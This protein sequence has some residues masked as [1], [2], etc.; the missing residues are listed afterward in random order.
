MKKLTAIAALLLI[1]GLTRAEEPKK[2]CPM[3]SQKPGCCM[4]AAN[5]SLSGPEQKMKGCPMDQEG[6]GDQACC[7]IPDKGLAE[8][9]ATAMKNAKETELNGKMCCSMCDLKIDKTCR[10]VFKSGETVYY[11]MGTPEAKNLAKTDGHGKISIKVN[12]KIAEVDGKKYLQIIRF[13]K[14]STQSTT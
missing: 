2:E 3:A 4:K 10:H 7:F 9:V 11:L 6:K 13:A 14:A 12:G 1:T 5:A 8:R